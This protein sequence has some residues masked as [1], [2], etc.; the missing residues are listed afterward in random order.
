[1]DI[2]IM[3]LIALLVMIL[4]GGLLGLLIGFVAKTFFVPTDPRIEQ[5]LELLPAANCGGCGFAGCADFAKAL[6]SGTVKDPAKCPANNAKSVEKI[7]ELLGLI[8]DPSVKKVAFVRCGGSKKVAKNAVQ[9]NGVNNCKSAMLVQQ[10]VKGCHYG[11]LGLGACARVCPFN[12]IEIRDHLAIVHPELCVGCGKCVE[13]CPKNLIAF[14]PQ[15]STVHVYCN[16]PER[17][18]LK[19][20]NC[21]SCCI[22]CKK[23]E[24]AAEPGQIIM[25]GFLATVNYE[26]PPQ[27]EILTTMGCP[28]SCIHQS[29]DISCVGVISEKREVSE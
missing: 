11:C 7:A 14:V 29:E 12:A 21:A 6:V 17:G 9:Y 4:M 19:R 15:K 26:N 25:Q 16:S 10:G 1:M 28:T 22:G 18:A 8:T 13:T 24:R 27:P 3:I 2:L 23:C 5:V 20:Q